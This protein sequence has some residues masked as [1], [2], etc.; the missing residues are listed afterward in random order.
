M[1]Y[2]TRIPSQ[3]AQRLQ[4]QADEIERLREANGELRKVLSRASC[5]TRALTTVRSCFIQGADCA[6]CRALETVETEE[7]ARAQAGG[8]MEIPDHVHEWLA[9]HH[10]CTGLDCGCRGT[11]N[12]EWLLVEHLAPV[13]KQ[14]LKANNRADA[15][16]E[17]VRVLRLAA[18]NDLE[19]A[20]V[21]CGGDGLGC[22][23]YRDYYDSPARRHRKCGQCPMD[24]LVSTRAALA[25]E[26]ES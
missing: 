21:V 26:G 9:A 19:D 17:R 1:S 18:A 3:T 11:T 25:G 23:A 2:P 8:A 6:M 15:A 10:C 22:D 4:D 5:P 7:L 20:K 24:A 14:A 12:A 13:Y 16:E